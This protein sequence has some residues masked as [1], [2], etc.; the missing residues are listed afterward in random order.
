M[1]G[2]V[3]FIPIGDI[4]HFD[5]VEPYRL[6][7]YVQK[8]EEEIKLQKDKANRIISDLVSTVNER[9]NDS[10]SSIK[11][12][13]GRNEEIGGVENNHAEVSKETKDSE[14]LTTYC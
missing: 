8:K 7:D 12:R 10:S 13:R 11:R 5:A 6:Q 2:L 9:R 14:P 1:K 4:R 3:S